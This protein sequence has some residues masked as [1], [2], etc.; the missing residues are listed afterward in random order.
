VTAV[1]RRGAALDVL[2][3]GLSCALF[4]AICLY[5]LDLPG[6]YPDEAF[7]VIPAMQLVL[8]HPVELQR[9][10]GA[11]IFGLDLPL[12][13]SSDY[14]G[15]TSTYLAL[16]FFA[17]GGI[18]VYS[19]RLMTVLVGVAALLL[20][21]L[22]ARSWFGSAEARIAVLLLATSPAWVFWSRLG[23]YVV[24]EVVPIGAGALLALTAWVR[25]RPLGVRNGPLY[26]AA[27]LLGLGLATKL[28]F[29][30]LITALLACGFSLYGRML[31]DTRAA[32]LRQ[33]GRWALV[34][35]AAAGAFCAG[36][37]PFLLYN[38]MTRGT[39]NLLRYSL[40]SGTTTHG[41][42]NSAFVRNLWTEADA[43]RVLL[44]GSYFWFQGALGRVY[45]NPLTPAI[46][47]LAAM[48]L[49]ALT[50]ARRSE[51][52][53]RTQ[54]PILP[55]ATLALGLALAGILAL[56]RPEGTFSL[57]LSAAALAAGLVGVAILAYDALR[58]SDR[59]PGAAW[60]LL[61]S[62]SLSGAVWWFAGS[63]RP[64][65]PA[66]GGLLGLWPVDMAGVLFWASG[67]A[68]VLVLGFD[69]APA[70]HQRAVA[71]ALA[72]TGLV[73][74]QSAVT[75][76]GLWA[77]HLLLVLPLPQIVIA[78]FAVS[79]ARRLATRKT[80]E[81]GPV[82][83]IRTLPV[84]LT[85]ACVVALDLLVAF[86]YHRDLAATGGGSTFS[87]AIYRLARYLD[88][89]GPRTRVVA[90][91][92]GF[93]RPLQFLT[94]ERVNPVEAYGYTPEPTPEYRQALRGLLDDP[95]AIYLFHTPDGTAYQRFTSFTEEVAA[96][97]KHAA[98]L[99]T[100]YHRDGVPVYLLYQ[101]R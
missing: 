55:G 30:W 47:A 60:I 101:V 29:L 99:E 5:Q 77:T 2:T 40:T 41:V 67:A 1:A 20:T 94:L 24:S 70:R 79:L 86:S 19:L 72:I 8:G 7:D 100:F 34:A 49:V 89:Q 26:A 64:E 73:V 69:P 71:A 91:D 21:F 18:N 52:S 65:G 81:Q 45:F 61:A 76:S 46:F 75:L 3:V 10:A 84:V 57:V 54:V 51:G 14:Q 53:V 66:P 27:F 93:K 43:L 31:W 87:D 39:L 62:C 90:M 38:A 78:A 25:S 96:A 16:P 13:S 88:D 80:A 85:L 48:G 4:M 58:S 17:L 74:A 42:N 63:G 44:D 28:L 11:H 56:A 33:G 83:T 32:W 15:V 35:L 82:G 9:G 95:G 97:G 23:V 37:F 6:L 36:A 98:L 12:M 22:L 92:W 50:L 59:V 68:L